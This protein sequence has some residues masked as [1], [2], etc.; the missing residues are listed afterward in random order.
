MTSILWVQ[1]LSQIW[2]SAK[3]V[4][5]MGLKNEGMDLFALV[6]PTDHSL[7][8]L[9]YL[10]NIWFTRGPNR[11]NQHDFW[12]FSARR[13]EHAAVFGHPFSQF[14][15]GEVEDLTN[16]IHWSTELIPPTWDL[17]QNRSNS[18]QFSTVSNGKDDFILGGRD[19]FWIR[20]PLMN[21]C[22]LYIPPVF[23]LDAFF[24]LGHVW[25]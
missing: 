11:G 23:R 20:E 22:K 21:R 4:W 10:Y 15:A 13:G 9:I 7:C 6:R 16:P 8:P 1:L 14:D 18:V 19:L 17:E 3:H 25:K 5:L 2:S 24:F 12:W